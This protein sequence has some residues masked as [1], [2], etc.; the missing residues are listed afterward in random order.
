MSTEGIA[1]VCV[2][3]LGLAAMAVGYQDCHEDGA[4]KARC[5]EATRNICECNNAYTSR[6]HASCPIVAPERAAPP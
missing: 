3:V 6:Q 1:I 2:T 5:I 4:N